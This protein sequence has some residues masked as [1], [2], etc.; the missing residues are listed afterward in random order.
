MTR[1][2]RIVLAGAA[3]G[4]SF[5]ALAV[6]ALQRMLP[7]PI[8]TS[9]ADHIAYALTWDALAAVPFFLMIVAVGNQR[10][11]GEAI[12]PTLHKE[13]ARMAV[14]GRVADNTTQQLLLFVVGSLALAVNLS[15]QRLPIVGAAAITFAFMR[16]AFWIGYRI[17]PLYRAFG[18]AGT[19]YLNFGM[20]GAALW[21]SVT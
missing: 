11:F 6:W 7:A 21:L 15:A 10:F 4:I 13:S 12:D 2:Q 5:M 17:H 19:A 20:L 1:D 9:I 18:F 14:D 3:S 16:T 8:A